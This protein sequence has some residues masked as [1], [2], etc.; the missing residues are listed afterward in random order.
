[1]T[2]LMK[3]QPV[4]TPPMENSPTVATEKK[5]IEIQNVEM[6]FD[7]KKG[8]FHALRDINLHIAKGE[9]I[10]LICRNPSDQSR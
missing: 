3:T 10:T 7:T 4:M 2:Q 9:F 5:Y 1:M 6:R 8:S